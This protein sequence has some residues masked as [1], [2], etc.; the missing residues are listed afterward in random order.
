MIFLSGFL[1][2]GWQET[3]S[4]RP[5]GQL[6][7]APGPE[8]CQTHDDS[9]LQDNNKTIIEFPSFLNLKISRSGPIGEGRYSVFHKQRL[10]V[11]CNS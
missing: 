11:C 9:D 6:A 2:L 5:H 8:A 10:P 7:A 3:P 1:V 4:L